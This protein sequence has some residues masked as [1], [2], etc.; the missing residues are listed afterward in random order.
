MINWPIPKNIK[1]LRGFLGLTG[2]YRR[3]VEGYGKISLPLTQLLKKDS[4]HWSSEANAAFH[5]LRTAMTTLPVLALPNYSKLFIIETY[6]FGKGLGAVLMQEGHLIAY[7]S[8]G[9]SV[10]NQALSIYE[11]ELMAVVLAVLKWRHY[12]LG[13]P[14][15]I[16]IDHQS[17][18]YLLEQRV[19]TPFQQKWIAKLI[20]YDY[21]ITYKHGKEN[22]AADALSKREDMNV[23]NATPN[24]LISVDFTWLPK[25]QLSWQTDVDLQQLIAKLAQDYDAIP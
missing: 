23:E 22:L 18:K 17:L 2:Y 11:K 20:R 5:T 4:F 21:E 19:A 16:R 14:F 25:V 3:F 9:L 1:Q 13:R 10:K 6:A 12:L 7:W 24:P 15:L 8:K